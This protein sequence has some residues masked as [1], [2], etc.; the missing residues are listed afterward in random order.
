MA[1][2]TVAAR[3]SLLLA[4]PAAAK[5]VAARRGA[6][7]SPCHAPSKTQRL[8]RPIHECPLPLVVGAAPPPAGAPPAAPALPPLPASRRRTLAC[9]SAMLQVIRSAKGGEEGGKVWD[10]SVYGRVGS[11]GVSE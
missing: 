8:A 7:V 5:P 3:P 10:K 9:L 11:S 1:S 4:R 6:L 2:F